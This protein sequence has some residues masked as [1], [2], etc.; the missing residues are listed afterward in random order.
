M[1]ALAIVK[2]KPNNDSIYLSVDTMG[3]KAS[4]TIYLN[5]VY[6]ATMNDSFTDFFVG[7]NKGL[8]HNKLIITTI[9][10]DYPSGNNVSDVD[11]TLNGA[12]SVSPANPTT[13]T[14]QIQNG[15]VTI[16]HMMV[17]YF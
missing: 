15:E 13:S 4:T 5:Q 6:M 7:T 3:Y 14:E 11:Y 12:A 8:E 17:Y 9:V 1:S 2:T 10:F 16:S